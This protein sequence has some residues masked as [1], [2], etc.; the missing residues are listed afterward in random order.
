[1]IWNYIFPGRM[2]TGAEE[3][4][5]ITPLRCQNLKIK[6]I[7]SASEIF[8]NYFKF[9]RSRDLFIANI[10]NIIIDAMCYFDASHLI[11]AG[12]I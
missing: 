4:L 2:I 10:F 6:Y 1:M 3:N 7:N 8:E 9:P 12:A 11:K 5:C